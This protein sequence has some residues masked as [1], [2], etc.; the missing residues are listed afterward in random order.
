M[1]NIFT[2]QIHT[3][4][5]NVLKNVNDTSKE[6]LFDNDGQLTEYGQY[7]VPMVAGDIAKYALIKSLVPSAE[8]KQLKNGQITYD[9]KKL[10]KEATLEK[11]GINGESPEDE[12]NQIADKIRRGTKDLNSADVSIVS[13]AINKRIEG[14]NTNSFKLAEVMVDRSGLGLDWRIDAAKDVAD[15]DAIRNRT[16]NYDHQMKQVIDVWKP[17][18]DSVKKENPNSYVVAEFTD[19]DSLMNST[20]GEGNAWNPDNHKDGAFET[21][22]DTTVKILNKTGMNTEANYSHFYSDLM[23]VFGRDFENGKHDKNLGSF[24]GAIDRFS[25]M[26]IDYQRNAYTFGGNHD[27]PRMTECYGMDMGIFHTDH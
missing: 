25:Q 5:D 21:P 13:R 12:A 20:Y 8:T 11:L 3:F 23:Y 7:V 18:I 14:T 26:P 9:Y 24:E 2:T 6:K 19:F 15:M 16:D 1:N 27:K 10:E 22:V 17:A 4:A